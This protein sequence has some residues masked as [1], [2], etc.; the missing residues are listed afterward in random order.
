M[1]GVLSI[2]RVVVVGVVCRVSER[3]SGLLS[4]V[5]ARVPCRHGHAHV[6]Y[7][8]R[9]ALCLRKDSLC[10]AGCVRADGCAGACLCLL[11]GWCCMCGVGVGSFVLIVEE[12]ERVFYFIYILILIYIYL[13]IE[14]VYNL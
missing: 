10:G 9:Y 1:C 3:A 12:S 7:V 6:Y 14:Y 2:D 13:I 4:L 11:M 8:W 5:C